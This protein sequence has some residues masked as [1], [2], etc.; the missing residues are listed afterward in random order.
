MPPKTTGSP[1]RFVKTSRNFF[2]GCAVT[3]SGTL[4]NNG[5]ERRYFQNEKSENRDFG[6]IGERGSSMKRYERLIWRALGG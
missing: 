1:T 2:V 3:V 5:A 4:N 6:T